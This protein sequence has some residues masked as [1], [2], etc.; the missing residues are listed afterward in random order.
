VGAAVLALCVLGRPA[1]AQPGPRVTARL[2]ADSVRIGE[3]VRLTLRAERAVG[4]RVLFPPAD[5]G[6]DVFGA[7]EVVREAGRGTRSLEDGRAVDSVSYEVTTFALDRVR[8]PGLPIRVVEGADTTRVSTAARTVPVASVVGADASGLRTG[9]PLLPFPRPVG[10]WLL[11]GAVGAVLIG[12]GAYWWWRRPPPAEEGTA[13]VSSA[14]P[15]EA[16]VTRLRALAAEADLQSP[17]AIKAFYVALARIL[18][19]YLADAYDVAAL[20]TTTPEVVAALTA[21]PDVPK[22][23]V[24]RV[25][26]VLKRADLVK[27]A[28]VRPAPS[29][30]KETHRWAREAVDALQS[31]DEASPI[32][33]VAS[34]N[35]P[36]D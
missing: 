15:H 7:L 29:A 30:T 35:R 17:D 22:A 36:A 5:A 1:M 25:E 20:E 26:A 13:R 27:F 2:S 14:A 28:G 34:A 18:R 21:R 4:A 8:V 6:G 9:A 3:R 33:G 10:R 12:G 16:V 24:E 31:A 32:D 11:W 19:V 23:A